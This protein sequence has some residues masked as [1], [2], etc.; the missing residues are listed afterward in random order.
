MSVMTSA[1]LARRRAIVLL[2]HS[3][4]LAKLRGSRATPCKLCQDCLEHY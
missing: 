2:M 3:L 4:W 1:D